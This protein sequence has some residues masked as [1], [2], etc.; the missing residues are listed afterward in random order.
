MQWPHI[1]ALGADGAG[2]GRVGN[3]PVRKM[4]KKSDQVRAFTYEQL[5][6]HDW[7]QL[8]TNS[9]A[10]AAKPSMY[11]ERRRDLLSHNGE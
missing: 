10:I 6:R 2:G 11:T 9:K 8:D 3:P 5:E 4:F 1:G 7:L